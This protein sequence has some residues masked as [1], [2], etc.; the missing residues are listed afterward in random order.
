MTAPPTT[1]DL[2]A[3]RRAM[4]RAVLDGDAH[5]AC[6]VVFPLL[7]GGLD[8]EGVLL[9]VIAKVQAKVGVE[10]AANRV[11]VAQEHAASAVNDRV[12]TAVL[13]H[14]AA[15]VEDPGR[16]GRV[17][18]ACV[19][20][21][22]HALPARLLAEVLRLR[23]WRVDFLGAQVPTPHLIRHVHHTGPLAVA[24]S[25]SIPTRLPVAHAA[26]SACQATGV[27][28]LV[29]GAAFGPD[30]RYAR[31][32]G[33]D[34]WAPDAREAAGILERGLPP[35]GMETARQAIEDLP[36]LGDQEFTMVVGTARQLVKQTMVDLEDRIPAMRA[37]TEEQRH[38]TA[39][40]IAHLVDFLAASLYTDDPELF[41][42][43]IT[44][45]ASILT[46]RGVPAT[47][48][49]PTLDLL[50]GQLRDFPRAGHHVARARRALTTAAPAP[51]T[52]GSQDAV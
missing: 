6:D 30:G 50:G 5:G 15:R 51:A 11:S 28:V 37:Y 32:F 42:R 16:R 40:D 9:D 2:P 45:M 39:E 49:R 43:F 26:I 23:G 8:A 1:V 38:H 48:L 13:H 35:T 24:L 21:E 22:W 44:W 3:V 29:G 7:D 36:H 52:S 46:A 10:W 12:I 25:S 31:Q 47:V 14:P 18:V 19:D 41:T 20:Q 4:W 17:T 34:A 33:A 27:P